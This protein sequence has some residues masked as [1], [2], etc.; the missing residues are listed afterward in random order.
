MK[1]IRIHQ[2]G[3]PEVMNLEDIETSTPKSGEVLIKVAAAGINYADIMQR[4]GNYLMPTVLPMTLGFEVA[5]TVESLGPDIRL[6][7]IG[8]RVVAYVNGGYAEYAVANVNDIIPIPNDIDFLEA[9]AIFTQGH[10]AYQ[11]LQS[12]AK[13]QTGESVLVHAAAGGVGSFAVQLAK[14]MGAGTVIG[15]A[16]TSSKLEFVRRLGADIAINYTDE[17]WITQVNEATNGQGINII[18][19]MVGGQIGKQSLQCL[20]PFGRIVI[21]GAASGQMTQFTGQ[22]LIPKNLSVIGY[23]IQLQPIERFTQ[24]AKELIQYIFNGKLQINLQTFPLANAVTAH[25][26]I[27]ERK[28][29]GKVVLLV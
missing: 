8:T 9:T 7:V 20:A 26:A 17:N 23:L 1:A 6:P 19:E 27:A 16:S 21:F 24:E 25:Q 5:G 28:T 2:V 11:I 14:L 3:A 4:Q 22:H 12:S 29:T 10:T 15:T 18:L 13:L